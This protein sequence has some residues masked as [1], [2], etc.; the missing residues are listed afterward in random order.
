MCASKFLTQLL[1]AS[2]QRNPCRHTQVSL[3]E[4]VGC[5]GLTEDPNVV[6]AALRRSVVLFDLSKGEVIRFVHVFLACNSKCHGS[7]KA[8]H[9]NVKHKQ[10]VGWR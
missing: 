2:L 9:A 5:I 1:Y 7:M 10:Q 4:P 8:W 6:L 3:P